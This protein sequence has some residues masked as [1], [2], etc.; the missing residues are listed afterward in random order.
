MKTQNE[1]WRKKS[2]QKATLETKLL[3]VDQILSGQLSNNQA[4][5]KYD[6]P[7]TTITY[8]LRKYS[9]L[10]QQN[11]GMSKNDEIKKLKEKIEEL[12]FQKDFQQDIIA[13]MELITGVDMSKKSLPKTLAKEI[14]QKKKQRIKENGSMDVLGYLNKPF[15]KDSKPNKNNK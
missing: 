3:V 11:T 8:W 10:V 4:S 7:R 13:D 14:E 5:K 1:H 2:Y 12:E 9:T 6:I 15:T